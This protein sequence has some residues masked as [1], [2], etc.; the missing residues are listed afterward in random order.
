M[1]SKYS[2]NNLFAL[3]FDISLMRV[4]LSKYVAEYIKFA[5]STLFKIFVEL[6]IKYTSFCKCYLLLDYIVLWS[7][8]ACGTSCTSWSQSDWLMA[9]NCSSLTHTSAIHS[10]NYG[11]MMCQTVQAQNSHSGEN[12]HHSISSQTICTPKW[13]IVLCE[14]D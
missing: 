14:I 12:I 10:A 4:E 9:N 2:A 6:Y 5:R 13:E 11:F 7:A 1:I 3:Y 8:L